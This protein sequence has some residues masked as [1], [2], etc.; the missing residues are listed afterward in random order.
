MRVAGLLAVLWPVGL[1]L[2][3]PEVFVCTNRY[4]AEKGS[5]ATITTFNFLCP[6]EISLHSVN[7]LGRWCLNHIVDSDDELLGVTRD[8]M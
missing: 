7:C 8:P 3:T 6:N 5:D 1:A 4:C 2:K